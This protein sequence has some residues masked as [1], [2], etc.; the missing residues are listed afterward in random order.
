MRIRSAV[1]RGVR[2]RGKSLRQAAIDD[3]WQVVMTAFDN[4][5]TTIIAAGDVASEIVPPEYETSSD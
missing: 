2:R 1:I 5:A 3:L 4:S